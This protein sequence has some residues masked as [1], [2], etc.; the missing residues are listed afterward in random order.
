LFGYEKA[1]ILFKDDNSNTL[2]SINCDDYSNVKLLDEN[3]VKFPT[4]LGLSGKAA[5]KKKIII[6]QNGDKDPYYASE[7]D[8]FLGIYKIEN[9]MIA[10]F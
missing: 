10:P 7:I 6:N 2:Y 3:I 4:S 9:M 1:G 8:N 5:T